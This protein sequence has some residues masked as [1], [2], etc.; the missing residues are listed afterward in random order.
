[1]AIDDRRYSTLHDDVPAVINRHITRRLFPY[2]AYNIDHHYHTIKFKILS[3][4]HIIFLIS[5][6]SNRFAIFSTSL[7]RAT[8]S[9]SVSQ[10]V[11]SIFHLILPL[12]CIGRLIV[13]VWISDGSATGRVLIC[14]SHT[15]PVASQILL[16]VSVANGASS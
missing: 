14:T 5:H 12:I 11:I 10:A 16:A 6:S 4:T 1:M 7:A 3:C 15:H 2:Y 13:D 9:S 8:T